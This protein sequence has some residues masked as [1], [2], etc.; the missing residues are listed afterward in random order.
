M[1]F[2]DTSSDDRGN[3]NFS[4]SNNWWWYLVVTLPL[5]AF[6]LFSMGGWEAFGKWRGARR[7]TSDL[8]MD[9]QF[10]IF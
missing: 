5:T 6:V 9:K 1:G 10:W 7:K 2:F 3:V 8:E 4:V